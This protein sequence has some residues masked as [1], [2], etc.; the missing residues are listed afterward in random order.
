VGSDRADQTAASDTDDEL[1]RQH[2]RRRDLRGTSAKY[3]DSRPEV[4]AQVAEREALVTPFLRRRGLN[5]RSRLRVLDVGCGSG[6]ELQRWAQS[7]VETSNL[8]GIDLVEARLTKARAKLTT[9]DI[10]VGPAQALPWADGSFDVV[11]Q[12]MAFSSMRT[13]Q[14]R[15]AA[16]TEMARVVAPSGII[17]WYDFWI[18][19][20]NKETTPVGLREV[21]G[22]FPGFVLKSHRVTLAPPLARLVAPNAPT[23]ARWLNRVPAL[24][25]HLLVFLTRPSG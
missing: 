3:D 24:R 15:Q 22:L 20:L 16:A 11:C 8:C 5:D 2:Y 25:S 17:L 10:R 4:Q 12:Y 21:R 19:P 1:I 18:N 14:C 7:G 13:R 6:R 9:A 23:L